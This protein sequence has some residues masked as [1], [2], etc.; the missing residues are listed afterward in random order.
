MFRLFAYRLCIRQL[1]LLGKITESSSPFGTLT[2]PEVGDS[3]AGKYFQHRRIF[4]LPFFPTS[5]DT[6]LLIYHKRNIIQ[7]A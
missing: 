2:V 7:K 1:H 5:A 3:Q 6:I 4:P